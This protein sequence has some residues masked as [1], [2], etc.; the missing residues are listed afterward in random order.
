[1]ALDLSTL[2]AEQQLA[3][4]YIGYYDRAADPVGEDFWESAVANPNLSLAD[5]AT[6]F[7]TQPETLA[8]YPFLEDPTEAEAEGFIAEVYLNLFNR[9]PDQAGLDFWSDALISA[10]DGTGTLSVGEIILSIIEG[11]QNS[12]EGNDLTTILN[13]IEVSTTWTDSADAAGI[14]YTSDTSAQ[15][16]AKSIIEGVTDVPATVVAAKS[17]IDSFFGTPSVPGEEILLTSGTDVE[18][19]TADDDAFMGY[20]QQNPFAGGISNSL[21]SADR[22]DGGAGNDRLY[23]ELTNEFLGTNLIGA[24]DIQPRL[25]NIEEIDIEARDNDF[26]GAGFITVD[27]KNIT[28]HEEIGSFF[29]DGDLKIENLTTLTAGGSARNTS[30]IT[31]TMDHTDNFNTDGDASDLEALFDN[32]YLLSGQEAEGKIFYFLLDEDAELANNPNR[33]NN[34]DVD[35][36]RFTIGEGA[37]AVDVVLSADAANVAGTHQGFVNALQPRLQE[38]IADG[39]LPAGTTLTLDPTVTDFTFLDDGSRSDDIPAIV[40]TSGDGTRV[41]ATGFTRIEEPIGEYDVYGRFNSENE[42]EDQPI[43]VDLDLHKAGRGGEGGDVVIGG[44]SE[45]TNEDSIAD[46]I[47]VI[48]INVLGAGDNDPNGGMTKPSNVGTITSTGDE[49]REVYIAT[50]AMFASGETF[51]SLTVRNG[52]DQNDNVDA[53]GAFVDNAENGDLELINADAFLGDLTL[54]DLDAANNAGRVTNADT[55]T[56]QGGGDVELGLLLDGNEVD[57]AYS[58]TTGGGND[59]IDMLIDGDALD[60]AGSS[61]NISTGGGD[62]NVL[63]DFNLQDDLGQNEQLNQAILDNVLVET[64]A[65][66]DTITID[67]DAFGQDIGNANIRAGEGNDTVYTDGAANPVGQNAVWAFNFD[68]VRADAQAGGLGGS[69]PDDLP[70]VQTSL[71]YVGGATVTVTLSGAGLA[72]LTAGGGVMAVAAAGA[73]AGDDG[74]E[75]TSTIESLINGNEYYGDQRDVNA[76]VIDAINNDDVLGKLLVASMGA[77]NTVVVASLTS[78]NFAAIDLRVDIDQRDAD[79]DSYANAV[80]SEAQQVFS[81]SDLTLTN[82]WGTATF[83]TPASYQATAPGANLTTSPT[84]NAWYDGLSVAGGANSADDNLHTA[85]TASIYEQDNDI[86]GGAGDDVIVLS[87]DAIADGVTPFTVSSNNALMNGASNQTIVLTG[88]NFGDDTVMNFTTSGVGATVDGGLDFLDFSA[89]LTSLQNLSAA[90]GS[91]SDVLI[92]VTLDT[93]TADVQANEVS[94]VTF[95]NTDDAGETFE[96]LSAS[97][98]EQLFNNGGGYTG[99]DGDSSF[100]SLTAAGANADDEYSETANTDQLINGAAKSILMVEN[101]DNDGEY[102]VFELSWNGDAST[103]ADSTNNGTVSANLLGSLDFGDSL[104]GLTESN[105]VGSN[106]YDALLAAG[107]NGGG[108]LPPPPPPPPGG[109][110]NVP[111]AGTDTAVTG[112]NTVDETFIF[113]NENIDVDITGFDY[114]NDN[115]D[116]PDTGTSNISL[117]DTALLDGE[118]TLVW[119]DAGN[120]IEVDFVGLS[121][122]DEIALTSLSNFDIV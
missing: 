86:D 55:I 39:T 26:E 72:D 6:D 105:L 112:D 65:G 56:A 64:G 92:P 29:S 11:A 34:I 31:I 104:A 87:T 60:F 82:L 93:N 43:S 8:A 95:D 12:A 63:I 114:V 50:D 35:G 17:T 3:A 53:A 57:Q 25:K 33:L 42:V 84:A 121:N 103:D 24:T 75:A 111:V 96:A 78:G 81:N 66:N 62:D 1:M 120:T 18:T 47:E 122:A 99:F 77:D 28:D 59:T 80:L 107:L 45:N 100:G 115:L 106:A 30:E 22:L 41:E 91:D 37:D 108:V 61:V 119:Q 7:A 101:A 23:A 69:A 110:A 27:A 40:L 2:N 46:G 10:I 58:V 73:I 5:I 76:A 74:Y 21:S 15:N 48:N 79:T 71:A 67:D 89:Y 52:F 38:L 54:G 85:G 44:K 13:K 94:V 9:A 90:A 68:N 51:A 49:L 88:A 118:I 14:D 98:V 109:G 36:I 116:F 97:V 4:I 32:D 102:K 117:V 16:S 19:G 83:A 20:I 113:A 70:G